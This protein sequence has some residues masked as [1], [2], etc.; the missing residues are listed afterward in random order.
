MSIASV[1]TR[2]YS[3]G[4]F[5]GSIPFVSTRGYSLGEE[6]EATAGGYRKRRVYEVRLPP[7][8]VEEKKPERKPRARD[9]PRPLADDADDV[10]A[11]ATAELDA[12]PTIEFDG[13]TDQR[14]RD[15]EALLLILLLAE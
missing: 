13:G 15:E 2:G 7:E 9:V 14:R 5:T 10:I 3:N 12:I 8:R 11:R 6:V 4:A 1:V